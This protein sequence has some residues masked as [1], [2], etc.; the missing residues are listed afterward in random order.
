MKTKLKTIVGL[1]LWVIICVQSSAQGSGLDQFAEKT[2]KNMAGMGDGT[3]IKVSVSQSKEIENAMKASKKIIKK[4]SNMQAKKMDKYYAVAVQQIDQIIA[5]APNSTFGYDA[6]AVNG[7]GWIDMQDG[8]KSAFG[9][10][11]IV[12]KKTTINL[13][14]KDYKPIVQEAK[15][16]AAKA[17]W[18]FALET[19]A[20]NASYSKKIM[21][22]VDLK[23]ARYLAP[24]AEKNSS[25][26][27]KNLFEIMS[28]VHYNEG[29]KRYEAG[30]SYAEKAKA[31]ECWSQINKSLMPYKDVND[32]MCDLHYTEGMKYSS[33]DKLS[34][35]KSS[36]MALLKLAQWTREDYNGY[37][38]VLSNVSN[39]GAEIIYK[40]A[41]SVAA[42][43][44]FSSM[45]IAAKLYQSIEDEWVSNYKD[46]NKKASK[47]EFNSKVL[48]VLLDETGP[49]PVMLPFQHSIGET[50]GEGFDD[51]DPSALKLTVFN[52]SDPKA[53]EKAQK[54]VKYGLVVVK[55]TDVGSTVKYNEPSTRKVGEKEVEQ[56][57][58]YKE[59]EQYAKASS[60]SEYDSWNRKSPI[61]K[62]TDKRIFYMRSGRV[63]EYVEETSYGRDQTI[64]IWDCRK[65]PKKIREMKVSNGAID[66]KSWEVYKGDPETKPSDLK[67]KSPRPL[68]TIEVLKEELATSGASASEMIS[69]KSNE[70]GQV[71]GSE[72]RPQPIY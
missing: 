47:C 64:E 2:A 19:I 69:S 7:Q 11:P 44:D 38:A 8:L 70:I 12:A 15:S 10:G 6:I 20:G 51:L 26:S 67:A 14:Y 65:T 3:E 68:K 48:I 52:W 58:S 57:Y 27:E 28:E 24:L 29:L 46:A 34:D 9:D 18:D 5:N 45:G 40:E 32:K 17:H 42:V 21:S 59:G 71:I 39:K 37:K 33:S 62:A 66:K 60:R 4:V 13:M 53:L 30:S 49:K 31:G 36:K 43:A 16:K 25:Y 55:L 63:E 1:F 72:I 56:L 23:K 22:F 41:E 54:K 35:L 50:A 61:E